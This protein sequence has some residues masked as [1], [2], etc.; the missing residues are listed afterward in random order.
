MRD[1]GQYTREQREFSRESSTLQS[2][3]PVRVSTQLLATEGLDVR[4]GFVSRSRDSLENFHGK[5]FS[6]DGTD[7][8][9]RKRRSR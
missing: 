2:I 5:I 8:L 3:G 7:F 6:G 9:R 4:R 1:G